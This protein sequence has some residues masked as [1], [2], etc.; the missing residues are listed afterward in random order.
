MTSL[1]PPFNRRASFR[2][3]PYFFEQGR[4]VFVRS[5]GQVAPVL[6]LNF[7]SGVLDPRITFSRPSLATMY[8]ST[9]KL[10][11]APNNLSTYSENFSGAAWNASNFTRTT[12]QA[13]PFGG[14]NATLGTFSSNGG[15]GLY[16][17]ALSLAADKSY[18]ISLYA[19][20][21]TWRWFEY[22]TVSGGATRSWVDMQNG[23]AGATVN[24]TNFSVTSIGNGWYR[25]S[26][27]VSGASE[28]YWT[29]RDANGNA[30][31]ATTNSG[32]TFYVY[33]FQA[34]AVTYQTTPGTYVATTSAAY[35]GPR[36]DYNPSTLAARGLLIEEART[37]Y[38]FY[39]Q[40]YSN[41]VW[42]L[43]NTSITAN[44]TASPDGGTNGW[45]LE[46]TVAT[47]PAQI[48]QSLT[49][50]P[51]AGTGTDTWILKA[52]NTNW[53]SISMWDG[54]TRS[55]N[56][57]NLSTGAVGTLSAGASMKVTALGNG[58]YSVSVTKTRAANPSYTAVAVVDADGSGAVTL[59]KFIYIFS[60]QLEL[61]AFATSY[62]PTGSSSV[63]RSADSVYMT[64][65]N[66]SS[67][68]K[69]SEG[70]FAF[71]YTKTSASS[72]MMQVANAG[73]SNYHN[74]YSYSLFTICETVNTTQQGLTQLTT[75][76]A[77]V[78]Q[79]VAYGYKAND[80]A[81]CVD[82]TSPVVDTSGS[83]PNDLN[84]LSIGLAIVGSGSLNGWIASL[85][86]YRTRLPN[87]RLQALTT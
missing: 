21:G 4:G 36:F 28:F 52:G 73:G 25:I 68:Y 5:T 12:G 32:A 72:I 50:N 30:G 67:W 79:R 11:Y 78:A 7:L 64:G 77:G 16:Q 69:Q 9:G 43:S 44:S 27:K 8:D 81:G 70:T 56:Y 14:A 80:F 6:N 37:N 13:D 61:G 55:E 58:W 46:V 15:N 17:T 3:Q 57:V 51:A 10:T 84:R 85:T 60:T 2:K 82:G 62:I 54:S 66:F 74:F 38:A 75:S 33:G 49:T 39:S 40:T 1:F 76:T 59:G 20:F 71:N 22:T 45:K 47:Y 87:T 19:K 35:Y 86:Y 23:V 24:H 48:Y 83:V 31:A 53:A 65:S 18:I 63:A 41:A 34:E 42:S 29:P 26:A